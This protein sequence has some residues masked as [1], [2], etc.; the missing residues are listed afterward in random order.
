MENGSLRL[1]RSFG[2]CVSPFWRS[3]RV[4]SSRGFR[5][6]PAYAELRAAHSSHHEWFYLYGGVPDYNP[7]F[8]S[9]ASRILGTGA[10]LRRS[11]IRGLGG[12]VVGH[13][14]YI[15]FLLMF[16]TYVRRVSDE[17]L[18]FGR[19]LLHGVRAKFS[20]FF[21][22]VY[23]D[24]GALFFGAASVF[25]WQMC[26]AERR[27]RLAPVAGFSLALCALYKG[28]TVLGFLPAWAALILLRLFLAPRGE[29]KDVGLCSLWAA[30]AALLPCIVYLIAV[31]FSRVPDFLSLYWASQITHRFGLTWRWGA[32]FG[33][34]S[35]K[36]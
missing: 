10:F 35:W 3:E 34:R 21:S 29:L 22:N 1:A 6:C 16:F 14:Y 25:L 9:P 17:K 4:I 2:L 32:I 19:F 33:I 27:A 7:R 12:R 20:N 11:A 13:L 24:P 18:P 31:H 28:L 36:D 15:A 8:R 26:L 23:L 30:V 5:R